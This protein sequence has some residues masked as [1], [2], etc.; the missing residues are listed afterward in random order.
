M[1]CLY[2]NEE[3]E[4]DHP[5]VTLAGMR[6]IPP[7]GCFFQDDSVIRYHRE[8]FDKLPPAL[9]KPSV[10]KWDGGKPDH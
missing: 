4:A 10:K 3:L 5:Q 6:A 8:C 7:D 1:K 2:C 9:R